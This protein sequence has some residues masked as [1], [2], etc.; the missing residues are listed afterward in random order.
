VQPGG[1]ADV[2]G[3]PVRQNERPHVAKAL[4]DRCQF[5][6]ERSPVSRQPGVGDRDAVLAGDQVAVD[7]LRADPVQAAG[8][9]R[10]NLPP[11]RVI[12]GR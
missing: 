7:D 5:G 8:N 4:A 3:I 10:D 6:P 2:V 1:E 11:T 12:G 9:L